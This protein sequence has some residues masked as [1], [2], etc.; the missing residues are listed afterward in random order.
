MKRLLFPLI[1]IVILV[2]TV[3]QVK[4]SRQNKPAPAAPAAPVAANIMAEGR[5]VTYP[6]SQVTVGSDVAGTIESIR[7]EEKDVV[8]K[9][10]VLAVVRA[11]DTRAALAEARS[12]VGEA[13]ADI[14]LFELESER[15][16]RLFREDVG[17]KQAWEKAERD[18]DAAR[19]RRASAVAEVRRLEAVV[20]KTVIKA[21]I[22]GVVITRDIHPGE[23]IESGAPVVTIADL[24]KT[25]IEAEVDEFDAARVALG[26]N[27][28]IAAEGFD[29]Q[30]WRGTIEEIPDSVTSRRLKPQD[31]AKPID[32]R[33]L[34]VK[35]ALAEAAPLKLG[36]RVEV[37]IAT[38]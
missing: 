9:G 18:I 15:A 6:G 12:R 37:Q 17:S 14:R 5:V 33:V 34:L 25:R 20:A 38:R 31:A 30:K 29:G 24:T 19:A 22:D 8:R 21:P 26:A 4:A 23:A 28:S 2:V 27:A 1:G 10:D 7:V 16:Q 13:D 11:D 32:T 3:T 35:I 36:Q